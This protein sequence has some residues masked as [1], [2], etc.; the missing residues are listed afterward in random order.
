MSRL[1]QETMRSLAAHLGVSAMTVSRALRG[2]RDVSAQTRDRVV[3][4]AAKLGYRH[5][6]AAATLMSHIRRRRVS[7]YR[8]KIAWL[9]AGHVPIHLDV[10][11]WVHPLHEGVR[12]RAEQSGYILDDL[13]LNDPLLPIDR[14]NAILIARGIQGL[15]IP[16][17][18]PTLNLIEWGRYACT[19]TLSSPL[20]PPVHLA[21]TDF[22]HGI[23]E[24]IVH[25]RQ[26]GCRRVGLMLHS[27][28]DQGRGRVQRAIFMLEMASLPA[29]DQVPV[30]LLPD[31]SD[32]PTLIAAFGDWVRRY[33]PEAVLC[34]DENAL[35]WARTLC[36]AVPGELGLVHLTRH[37][38]L[39]QW[40]GID[41][42]EDQIGAAAVDLVV[43]QLA[44]GERGFPSFQ[45]E[46][47]IKGK[48][49][50]GETLQ[51]QQ[52]DRAVPSAV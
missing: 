47:L 2:A 23:G 13:W 29:R 45:K 28:Q 52:V 26:H 7:T 30:L 22:A 8:G 34:D 12:Q 35:D 18:H 4:A 32:T 31:P 16:G 15:I 14:L 21:G 25:L 36:I 11:R 37:L 10:S 39:T 38:Y 6:P 5:N 17:H 44:R 27:V 3:Q 51:P 50:E 42:Q 43:G 19:T 41:Q 49:V 9:D 20:A 24:A 33:Q 40:A 46:V 48:W 1:N